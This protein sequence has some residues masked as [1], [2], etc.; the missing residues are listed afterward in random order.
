MLPGPTLYQ[1]YHRNLLVLC[2]VCC[3]HKHAP[4]L[5]PSLATL[6]TGPTLDQ[7]YHRTLLVLWPRSRSLANAKR[8]GLAALL[9]LLTLQLQEA[10]AAAKHSSGA[11]AQQQGVAA[12]CK[13]SRSSSRS[14]LQPAK[15]AAAALRECVT[16]AERLAQGATAQP[17][18]G[19][20]SSMSRT[21][22]ARL[23][24]AHVLNLGTEAVEL[25][26]AGAAEQLQ[27][28]LVSVCQRPVQAAEVA[29]AMAAAAAG[30]DAGAAGQSLLLR[31]TQ[32]MPCL[33]V[34]CIALI[35][36][37]TGQLQQQLA[38]AAVAAAPAPA[39]DSLVALATAAPDLPDVQQAAV[40]KA[41]A[42]VQADATAAL[43]VKAA[44][45]LQQLQA[46]P[47]LQQQL[48]A[49]AAAVLCA[50]GPMQHCTTAV[51]LL[52][53]CKGNELQLYH[54]RLLSSICRELQS[55][56]A[57]TWQATELQQLLQATPLQ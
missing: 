54:E 52:Q 4:C 50:A 41:A 55:G 29:A 13:A 56:Q 31:V 51:L 36:G 21:T 42:A 19:Y 22:D 28:L 12:G 48:A 45:L 44:P 26:V 9:S 2:I 20:Y 39:V 33:P 43:A 46:I 30:L 38:E 57:S 40:A 11:P 6:H 53:C 1:V 10:S 7:V 25:G 3:L 18:G 17:S 5:L 16:E 15:E 49:A 32:D 8:A 35:K 37:L 47:Q 24:I 23:Q 27:Q 14:F 34:S